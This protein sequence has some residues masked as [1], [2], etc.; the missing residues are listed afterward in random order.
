[1]AWFGKFPSFQLING[2]HNAA[3]DVF[4]RLCTYLGDGLIYIPLLAYCIFFNRSFTVPAVLSIVIC[5]VLTHFFKRV[6]FPHAL[7]P[8]AL[9]Q[10]HIAIHKINGLAI[11]RANSFPSGHTATAVSTALLLAM[12]AKRK[13]WGYVLPCIPLLVAY[14][15]VYLAQHFVTDVFGGLIIGIVTALLVVWW[16]EPFFRRLPLQSSFRQKSPGMGTQ[17][18]W[19]RPHDANP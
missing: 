3:L 6:V 4:F 1:M 5:L 7:R 9:E 8:L 10:A 16:Q 19:R 13:L 14:S 11:H 15:R 17:K 12:V 2:A 18:T